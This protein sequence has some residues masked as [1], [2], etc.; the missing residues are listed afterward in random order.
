MRPAARW[1]ATPLSVRRH[2]PRAGEH[3]REVLAQAGYSSDEIEAMIRSGAAAGA[4]G[5]R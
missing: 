4:G 2:A 1:S 5:D 3:T